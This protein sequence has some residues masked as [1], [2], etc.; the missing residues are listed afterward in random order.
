MS[1]FS[2]H[3]VEVRQPLI[4]VADLQA[5]GEIG[6]NLRIP[7][8]ILPVLAVLS[9]VSE[10]GPKLASF[11]PAG[12]LR[13]AETGAGFTHV[14]VHEGTI[15]NGTATVTFSNLISS[16]LINIDTFQCTVAH[17]MDGQV[18]DT[19]FTVLAG[20][21]PSMDVLTRVLTITN[22][23][24]VTATGYRIWGLYYT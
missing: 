24:G 12:A 22:T 5:M 8:D 10:V 14:E 23:S 2:S 16:V 21:K 18:F 1:N 15:M 4:P 20:E 19:A 17:S 3:L 6:R 11:T 9:G 13:I 7:A